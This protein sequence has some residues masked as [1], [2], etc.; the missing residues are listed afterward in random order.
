MIAA[1]DVLA[2]LRFERANTRYRKSL[3]AM[4]RLAEFRAFVV[5][6]ALPASENLT[7]CF[8]YHRHRGLSSG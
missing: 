7:A 8:E 5:G 1:V 6:S 3:M 4:T 2:T